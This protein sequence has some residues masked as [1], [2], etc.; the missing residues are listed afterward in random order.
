M[1]AISKIRFVN[2][3]YENGEKRYNDDIFQF[4]GHN[5]AILLENGGGKTV[6]VQTAIQAILPHSDLA[7]RKIKNTLMLENSAA[8]IA[9]EWILSE[10]PRRYGLTSVT[11]FMNK[12]SVDSFKYVYEYEEGD[13][14]SIEKIPFVKDSINGKKRPASKEEI[15]EYYSIMSQGKINAHIFTT[16]KEYHEYIENNFK[17]IPSEWR[18][19]ALINGAEGDVEKFFD[20]CQT[21]GQLVDN[22]LIPT[23]EEALAGNG[24]KEFAETFEKQR[25]HFKKYKQL[26]ARIDESKLVEEQ[27]NFY[28]KVYEAYDEVNS[29]LV[30]AKEK[31]KSLYNFAKNEE[32]ING[33]K[34][35]ENKEA[36]I[37]LAAEEEYWNR[38]DASYKLELLKQKMIKAEK[39]F[40]E[41]KD[42][43][44]EVISLKEVK[45]K[46]HE[47]LMVS[48]YKQNIKVQRDKI[49]LFKRQIDVLDKDEDVLDTNDKLSNNSSELRGYYLEQ[50]QNLNNEI[51]VVEGQLKNIEKDIECFET[52][53]KKIKYNE[54]ELAA[55]KGKLD[56]FIDLLTKDIR[57]IEK[58]ILYN[59]SKERIEEQ[60]EKW[61]NRIRDLESIIFGYNKKMKMVYGEK[62]ELI[63]NIPV[64]RE[65]LN[66]LGKEEIQL[67]EQLKALNENHDSL[68]SRIK[69]FRSSWFSV[70]SL[71][72]RQDTILEQIENKLERIREEKENSIL[73]ERLAHRW[74]DNY[75]ESEFYTADPSIETY[76]K[77]WRNGFNY[78][79]SGTQYI[80][81]VS[82]NSDKSEEELNK[83]YPYWT[84]SIITSDI[85]SDKLINKI[86]GHCDELSHPVVVMT[87][88]EARNKV[89]GDDVLSKK[90][91]LFPSTWSRNINQR[92]FETW[93]EEIS[94]KANESTKDRKRK[95]EEFRSCSEL[96]KDIRVFYNK[97]PHEEYIEMHKQQKILRDNIASVTEN[98]NKKEDR[99][100]DIDHEVKRINEA[101]SEAQG[102]QSIIEQKIF[103]G[104]E[105][106][107]KKTQ[108]E[109]EEAE[110]IKIKEE[111]MLIKEEGLKWEREIKLNKR[112]EEEIRNKLSEFNGTL[113]V[114]KADKL[115]NEV[116]SASPRYT[117]TSRE[118]LEDQRKIL[119]DALEK[120]QKGRESLEDNMKN[121]MNM[122]NSLEKDLKNLRKQLEFDVDEEFN[123]PMYGDEEINRIIEEL[124][125][126]KN[127][128]K[129]LKETYEDAKS[130]YEKEKTTYEIEE[131]R[132]Y[133]KYE[134][135]IS[136]SIP[137]EKVED[138]LKEEKKSIV[139]KKDY[140]FQQQEF[141]EKERKDINNSI[142][143]LQTYN[144][145]YAYLVEE[146]KE[147]NLSND[148]KQEFPYKRKEI[149][150]EI[151][152]NIEE[153]TEL[154][155]EKRSNSDEKR[156]E[157]IKFCEFKILD[158]KLK[159]MA[160]TGVQ[161]KNSYVDIKEW[162]NKMNERIMRTIEI[163]END[164]REHDKEVQQFINHLHSYLVTMVHELKQI[165]KKTRIKIE[166]NWKDVFLFTVPEWDAKDGKEELAR[167]IDWMLKQL[168]GEQF[169]DE[170]GVEIQNGVRNAIEKWLQ[171]KQLLQ[172]VMKQ[173]NIKVKCRK[174]TNDEK[175]S[176]LPFSWEVSNSWSGGEKWS[177]NMTLFLG[178]LNYLAEKRTQIISNRKPYRTVVVDNPFGKASSNHVLNP[179]FFIAQQLGFQIIALTAHAEGKF[180][181]TYFPIVYSCRLRNTNNGNNQIVTKERE[182]RKAF[183]RDSDP[184]TLL[185][186][187]Q[188]H[189][190][191]LFD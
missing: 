168:E 69:E 122:K 101:I 167:H 59:P 124:Q 77:T 140:L 98:V 65:K 109:K 158:V 70:N 162:Q 91:I 120:K 34:L 19:I 164:I 41:A 138:I 64:T 96:L 102:E 99:I 141:L 46:R 123:F 161:Y 136:F 21:T 20:K 154:L 18:N 144:G 114:L 26:K 175:M 40:M 131:R 189:Q 184:Q 95:E 160:V 191:N 85:E 39:R 93:K 50:E 178:V 89:Q 53:L 23:V 156:R 183:F 151:I 139:K 135:I 115:Y 78:I 153:I 137:L 47:N 103:K 62:Q 28:V 113:R 188:L 155:E 60:F 52:E 49:E 110:R 176:S 119:K 83:Y 24:T 121:T 190:M 6:F 1:P 182:I 11:L 132:F 58:E 159:E 150:D 8:H 126:L 71:Y 44:S 14:N 9:I 143:K 180:I 88:R 100:K 111:L 61:Q 72:L 29:R 172:I 68:L 92:N 169:K 67:T 179:V 152:K 13:G 97:Y 75:I 117:S 2:V 90:N 45:Q 108:K 31:V 128:L 16:V 142:V 185:R 73:N 36:Q 157:F 66:A 94:I 5:G 37:S 35:D 27:I 166:E 38:K 12:G 165:P 145:K 51:A 63:Q 181:S 57:H 104:K 187:G 74:L 42:R 146:I 148:I 81:R 171:S 10:K 32:K 76:I 54:N 133:S 79:E 107:R 170:N 105:Y 86:T 25:E 174:V 22:L 80:Q 116:I 106:S 43:Y 125:K 129:K 4:D 82:K 56:G 7:Q 33:E 147:T 163:A 15:G 177:K 149:V 127:P 87:E 173:N 30:K 3:I 112:I 186:L 55:A 134:E 48:K 84:I 118:V 130:A 17:I